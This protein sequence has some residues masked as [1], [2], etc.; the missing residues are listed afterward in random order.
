MAWFVPPQATDRFDA[1]AATLVGTVP[2]R[3]TIGAVVAAASDTA[4]ISASELLSLGEHFLI[5]NSRG[6]RFVEI[7]SYKFFQIQSEQMIL[8]HLLTS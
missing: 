3:P 1:R 2:I 5:P 4:R 7:F 6:R 8:N